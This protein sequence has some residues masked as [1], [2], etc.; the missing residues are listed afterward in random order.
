[1]I[2]VQ[3]FTPET[4]QQANP[5]IAG[6][7]AGQGLAAGIQQAQT[8][9]L[10]NNAQAI[11]NQYLS[12]SLQ[13]QLLGQQIAN[14]LSQNTL[15]FA[16]QMSQA[17]LNMKIAQARAQN[18]LPALYGTEGQANLGRAAQEYAAADL[19]RKQTPSLVQKSQ[20]DIYTDPILARMQQLESAKRAGYI[21]PDFL[22][23]LGGTPQNVPAQT[24]Q[25]SSGA[26]QFT[27]LNP[28]LST[29]ATPGIAPKLFTGND[30]NSNYLFY[31]TPSY[32]PLQYEQLQS[33][34]KEQGS[35]GVTSWN[36]AQKN[37]NDNAQSATSAL[38]NL[39]QFYNNYSQSSLT[40]PTLGAY[41]GIGTASGKLLGTVRDLSHE[42]QADN[43]SQELKASVAK[44]IVNSGHVTNQDYQMLDRM[45]P[46]REMTPQTAQMVTDYYRGKLGRILEQQQFMNAAK[47]QGVDVQ[48]AQTLWDNY[49][50]YVAPIFDFNKNKL[51][52]YPQNNW[53]S[54]LSAQKIQAAQQGNL[55]SGNINLQQNSNIQSGSVN[56]SA[57]QSQSQII[58]VV[59]NG[60][61]VNIPADKLNIALQRGYRQG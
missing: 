23:L 13:Q 36:D 8:Q 20:N 10:Q 57:N 38:N 59:K 61:Y 28:N 53:K 16:P 31:G 15:N 46:N 14:K 40:G 43:A 60:N 2:G 18:A 54:M 55:P 30:A 17:D 56:P 27:P 37:I 19:Q 48:T 58:R 50:N 42:Q 45:K 7:Q 34:A 47:N 32:S 6:M 24:G 44:A 22:S 11:R 4:F 51:N 26:S 3:N 9:Q 29:S 52:S 39:N 21:S 41:G 5:W 12:P 49:N 35:S 1:M 33:Q 25:V